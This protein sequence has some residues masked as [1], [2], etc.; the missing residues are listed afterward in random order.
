MANSYTATKKSP[1]FCTSPGFVSSS[2]PPSLF[3]FVFF[4]SM[5]LWVFV[6]VHIMYNNNTKYCSTEHIC[7]HWSVA[8]YVCYVLFYS[9]EFYCI[10]CVGYWTT[11]CEFF[12]FW[13]MWNHK[14]NVFCVG[15]SGKTLIGI[16][17]KWSERTGIEAKVIKKEYDASG[18][19]TKLWMYP[20]VMKEIGLARRWKGMESDEQYRSKKGI[21]PCHVDR[22]RL[23]SISILRIDIGK[24]LLLRLVVFEWMQWC[25]AKAIFSQADTNQFIIK[26]IINMYLACKCIRVVVEHMFQFE[27]DGS[28]E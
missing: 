23:Q 17:Y 27:S 22:I 18:G 6:A 25:Q 13:F 2:S 11:C 1:N 21:A 10:R 24:F 9:F 26:V 5:A 16:Y 8:V 14:I 3:F 7:S 12:N 15:S 28:P 4:R 20:S 19:G